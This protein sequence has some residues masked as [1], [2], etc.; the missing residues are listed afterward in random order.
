MI[1]VDRRAAA[2]VS[3]KH[4]HR[5]AGMSAANVGACNIDGTKFVAGFEKHG[6]DHIT[7]TGFTSLFHFICFYSFFFSS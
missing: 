1:M 4:K 3:A 6:L 5:H 2:Q 7:Q